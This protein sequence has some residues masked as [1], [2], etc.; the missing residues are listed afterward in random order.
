LNSGNG[1]FSPAHGKLLYLPSQSQRGVPDLNVVAFGAAAAKLK[2]SNYVA[3]D[4]R[5][6]SHTGQFPGTLADFKVEALPTSKKYF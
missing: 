6:A 3:N 1:L 2:N 4:L 5:A